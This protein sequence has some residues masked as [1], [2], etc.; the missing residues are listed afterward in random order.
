MVIDSLA[1]ID[2][3]VSQLQSK[4][5]T[6]TMTAEQRSRNSMIDAVAN[7]T[8][9]RTR[10]YARFTTTL[11][12]MSPIEKQRSNF[13]ALDVLW[14]ELPRGPNLEGKVGNPF[15]PGDGLIFT[16]QDLKRAEDILKDYY[17]AWSESLIRTS[18]NTSGDLPKVGSLTNMAKICLVLNGMK[19]RWLLDHFCRSEKADLDL[20][21]KQQ[22]L[23]EILGEDKYHAANFAT[24]QYRV[25]SHKWD[26]GDHIKLSDQEPLPLMLDREIASGSFG[27]VQGL[28]DVRTGKVY[29]RKEQNT[30]D[31]RG[32]LEREKARLKR[33]QHRHAVR[34]VKSYE[35]GPKFG[36]L[37][38]PVADT[39]LEQLL[40]YFQKRRPEDNRKLRSN[41]FLAFGCLSHGLAHIHSQKIRHK[42]IK[43]NNIL[44]HQGVEPRCTAKFIWADF[45]LAHDFEKSSHSRTYNPSK[46]SPK[47]AAPEIAEADQSAL[48][49]K[50]KGLD[51]VHTNQDTDE[52]SEESI[53]IDSPP[54][55]GRPRRPPHG[56]SSDIFSYGCVFLEILSVLIGSKIPK[57]D[58]HEFAFCKHVTTI[59]A[60]AEKQACDPNCEDSLRVL[61]QLAIKMIR[62]RAK[63]RPTIAKVV[64]DLAGSTTADHFFCIEC[65][66]EA[67]ADR[68]NWIAS[69][70][71]RRRSS[72]GK[73]SEESASGTSGTSCESE[74]EVSQLS[75]RSS[76][77]G[78]YL[79]PEAAA[80]P[81]PPPTLR[82]SSSGTSSQNGRGRRKSYAL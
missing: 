20:P 64:S 74:E 58:S 13:G 56:R 46:Y 18:P 14:D 65:L 32:H 49:A 71:R 27:T 80:R 61:F 28:R 72:G 25:V 31:A 70:K 62:Y 73:T 12:E 60:W 22:T 66:P 44:Y 68:E 63:K 30:S 15:N 55:A 33:I 53:D 3:T 17:D 81:R 82:L 37:L 11:S 59:Q 52:E 54:I 21:L 19:K 38:T 5:R 6:V 42:D 41:I 4:V 34:F 67:K 1:E 24:E 45:G 79:S 26:E 2:K 75:S 29:A 76:Q 51:G 35:R 40:A 57:S 78:H 39:D 10:S 47:Y 16:A 8:R 69:R 50:A 36:L 77:N 43:P 48:E 23:E 7:H 9:Q